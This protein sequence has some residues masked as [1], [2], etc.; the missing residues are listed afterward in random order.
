MQDK[1]RFEI[2]GK[3]L[4]FSSKPELAISLLS[5]Q[6]R[7]LDN[8]LKTDLMN[9]VPTTADNYYLDLEIKKRTMY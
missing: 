3:K 6:M 7:P 5:F 9:F 2:E 8:Q 4:T 1:D